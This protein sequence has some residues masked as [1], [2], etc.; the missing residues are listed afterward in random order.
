[1]TWGS[2]AEVAL[3][4]A[5]VQNNDGVAAV[6]YIVWLDVATEKR[7]HTKES[8]GILCEE[9]APASPRLIVR[10]QIRS[11]LQR[12]QSVAQVSHRRSGFQPRNR[13]AVSWRS[14]GRL[15][16]AS[17]IILRPYQGWTATICDCGFAAYLSKSKIFAKL[18]HLSW[19]ISKVTSTSTLPCPMAQ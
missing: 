17:R 1:M 4:E 18:L 8:P 3:P 13:H 12:P 14:R 7:A 5:V 11:H 6:L 16:R 15:V 9:A 2:A 19:K 10:T